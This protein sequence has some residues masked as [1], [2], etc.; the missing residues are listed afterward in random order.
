MR[1]TLAALLS[2]L[3]LYLPSFTKGAVI[4]SRN[5]NLTYIAVPVTPGITLAA[6]ENG[7]GSRGRHESAVSLNLTSRYERGDNLDSNTRAISTDVR[8]REGRRGARHR[9]RRHRLSASGELAERR[10]KRT[11]EEGAG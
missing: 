5:V 6:R 9:R 7:R 3:S 10:R 1:Y 4:V 8:A 11:G 2:Q